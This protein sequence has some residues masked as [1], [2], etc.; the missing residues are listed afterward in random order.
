MDQRSARPAGVGTGAYY[1]TW[2]NTAGQSVNVAAFLPPIPLY[3]A[4]PACACSQ[5]YT[6]LESECMLEVQ[7]ATSSLL[8]LKFYN[9]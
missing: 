9:L 1:M 4:V 3:E 2:D 5:Q 7:S 8:E 6:L